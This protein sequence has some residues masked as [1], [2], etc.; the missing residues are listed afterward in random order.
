M[1]LLAEMF[2]FS[3]SRFLKFRPSICAKSHTRRDTHHRWEKRRQ[4]HGVM[5]IS[6]DS[7]V[8]GVPSPFVAFP[9]WSLGVETS[10]RGYK[11]R[12][13]EREGGRNSLSIWSMDCRSAGLSQAVMYF[14]YITCED[15]NWNC[16]YE[17]DT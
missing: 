10:E 5:N 1:P 2:F 7:S 14:A 16:Q 12:D 15:P 13:R 9:L 4:P 8:F 3:P 17:S 11:T 6:D